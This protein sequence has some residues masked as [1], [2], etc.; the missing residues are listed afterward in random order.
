MTARRR[1]ITFFRGET[2]ILSGKQ[3]VNAIF[4]VGGIG[5]GCIGVSGGGRLAEWEIFNHAGKFLTNG[6][7]HFAVRAERDGQ[8][9]AAKVLHGDHRDSLSGEM[10]GRDVMYLGFG[11]GPDCDTMAGFPHFRECVM[12]GAFPAAR[13]SFRDPGFPGTAEMTAWSP[14]VPGESD[15]ASMPCAMFE[16][17][18]SNSTSEPFDGSVIAVIGN[19]WA[20]PHRSSRNRIERN[21]K[22]TMLELGN[23][24]DPEDLQYGELVLATDEPEVSFQQYLHHGDWFDYLEV[25]RHDLF[26]PGRFSDRTADFA[27]AGLLA[28]HFRL[29]PGEKRTVR[30]VLAWFVPNRC[31][32]WLPPE[33]LDAM[34]KRCGVRENRWRNYYAA[35]L[36]TSASD[37]ARRMFARYD[38]VRQAVFTFRDALHASTLPQAALDGAA[39]NLAVLVSPT[40]LRLED[41]TF[42][43]WEGVWV[44]KGSCFGSCQHVWNYAQAL[45][46]LFPDLERSM[47]EHHLNFGFDERG[48]LHFRAYLPKGL[49][50]DAAEENRPCADGAF[51]EVMKC[52]RE[53]RV[54]GDDAWLRKQ[55]D[56]IRKILLYAW[57]PDNPDRWDPGKTG[58]L[59]GRQHHTLDMEL[60]GPS[61]WLEA[62][63]LGALKAASIMAPIC[64]DPAFGEECAEIFARGREAAEALLWNGEYYCQQID[65]ADRGALAP[66]GAEVEARYWDAEHGGI[67]YQ[68][69]TG[70]GI[71][72]HLGDWYA[73]LYGLGEIFSPERVRS[74]LRAIRRY[75]FVPSMRELV[76][77]WRVFAADDEAGTIIC[78]WPDAASRPVIP[79]PY[80]A[81]VMTGFEWALASHFAL[82]GE[83][84]DAERTA[85]AIRGR[86]D[87]EKRN[88]WNEI[89]CGSNYARSMAAY[90]MLQAYSGFRYDMTRKV[91]G[92]APVVS[93]D[94]RCFWSL[95]KIWGEMV[96]EGGASAVK[97]LHGEAGFDRIEGLG[98]P[99]RAFPA[100]LKAGDVV[101]FRQ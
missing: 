50:P 80:H 68:I 55:W 53:W 49:R 58:L 71:D 86:Y 9:L 24:L 69:G 4:P 70:C 6:C 92:F 52:F 18:L 57:S 88:P 96:R 89:E 54:S 2:M 5:A 39:E 99:D 23:R 44:Q 42:W 36:C 90:A 27:R 67:K 10:F 45:P 41:G 63:Y 25:Y 33:T 85:R 59:T 38:R 14:F 32:D 20:G 8:V 97:I 94:F 17:S 100:V 22:L 7:S 51:G 46:L 77:T 98:T 40:C 30:F 75:N 16:I 64:G 66:Y 29:E 82:L 13:W 47:R 21:G 1:R 26:T 76:N 37:A 11:W 72:A 12:E 48:G 28:A 101:T 61:G 65:L 19:P 79:L 87:G 31:N 74:T 56:A 91:I 34:M 43:G 84:D 73:A 60:F 83:L 93:G 95:G 15:T 62:H 81:E 35:H 78:S 3:L